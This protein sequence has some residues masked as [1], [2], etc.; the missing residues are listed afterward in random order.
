MHAALV[1]FV[2]TVGNTGGIRT[3]H[4]GYGVNAENEPG[5][6]I[7]LAA[8]Y[9]LACKAIGTTP[10]IDGKVRNLYPV[11]SIEINLT[12]SVRE[13]SDDEDTAAVHALAATFPKEVTLVTVHDCDGNFLYYADEREGQP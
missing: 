8:A 4:G 5:P 1:A 7:D 6:W 11:K 13:E 12:R 10:I 2:E 9:L 3:E